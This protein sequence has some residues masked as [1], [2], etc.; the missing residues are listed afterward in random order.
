MGVVDK[1]K[2]ENMMNTTGGT[3]NNEVVEYAKSFL[4]ERLTT[5]V[6]NENELQEI[7][8]KL[9]KLKI[10]FVSDEEF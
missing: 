5:F 4:I 9:Q 7:K 2:L 3:I 8:N 1:E 6:S 10:E